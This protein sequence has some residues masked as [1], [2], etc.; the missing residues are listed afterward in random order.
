MLSLSYDDR[1]ADQLPTLPVA[2]TDTSIRKV[3]TTLATMGAAA[4]AFKLLLR[5]YVDG[6]DD[7]P[8]EID[9]GE[10]ERDLG[11]N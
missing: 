9:S 10:P 6:W 8:I 1:P 7:Q 5:W 2:A 4:A 11:K 3:I